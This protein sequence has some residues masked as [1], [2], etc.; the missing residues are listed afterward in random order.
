MQKNL[1][2]SKSQLLTGTALVLAASCF[3]G[4]PSYAQNTAATEGAIESVTVTG[5]RIQLQGYEAPTPVTVVDLGSLERD[6]RP[7][8]GDVLRNLPAFGA[9]SSPNNSARASLVSDGSAGLN[10][11]SLRNLGQLRTLVLFNGQRVVSSNLALGGTDL[12]TIPSSLVE[13][14]DVVTGGASASW[15]SDAV[16][17]VV[18]LIL[19][20]KL[21]GLRI[22]VEAGNN[23]KAEHAQYKGEVTYGQGFANDRGHV[24]VSGVYG[25]SPDT[26]FSNKIDGFQNQRLVN[27]PAY[28]TGAG[29]STS[30]PILIHAVN[31]GLAQ[32]TPGGIIS[33]GP[34][35]GIYFVGPNATPMRFD[36]GNVSGGYYT[37]GGTP[38]YGQ[39]QSDLGVL[40]FPQDNYTLFGYASYDITDDITASLQLNQGHYGSLVNTYSAIY[41]GSQ[42][43]SIEN[44]FLPASVAAQMLAAGVTTAPFGTSLT[45][46][47]IN[48]GGSIKG[49][50]NSLGVGVQ[51]VDRGLYRGVL[52]FDGKMNWFDNKWTWN[53]YFQ[54]G[55]VRAFYNGVNNQTN[56]RV[57]AAIDAVRVTTA[58]VGNSGLP[59][60]SIVCRSTLGA[61]T[62]GCIP[63][64]VFGTGKD[65]SQ[66]ASYINGVARAGG[67]QSHQILRQDVAAV[68]ATG[69]L[70]FGLEAGNVSTAFGIEYR[71][72]SGYAKVT[73]PSQA[74]TFYAG[75]PKNFSGVYSDKEAFVEFITPLLKDTGVKSLD[76]QLAGRYTDYSVS[77]GVETYKVG[78]TSEVNDDIRLRGTYSHDIRAPWLF[79]VF[80]TGAPITGSAID[81][82]TG[83]GV[84]IL[85]ITQGNRGLKPETANTLT[86]GVVLAPEE[87]IPGFNISA[88]W[89]RIKITGVIASASSTVTLAQCAA[90]VQVFCDNL[91]FAGPNGSLSAIISQPVNAA[92]QQTSGIDGQL[93]YRT[94]F[95]DGALNFHDVINYMIE[96]V[97]TAF[98]LTYDA[99]GAIGQ[100]TRTSVPKLK[101]TLT[102]TYA[103]DNWDLTAQGRVI[104]AAKL[105]NAWVSGRD[106]DN[107]TVPAIAYLDARASVKMYDNFQLYAAIDNVLGKAP[108]LVTRSSGNGSGY[109]APFRDTIYDAFGRV[110][111]VGLRA[112]F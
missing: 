30:V 22:N 65:T 101:S 36:Y 102:V 52:S 13:R 77:G 21:E 98:G 39:S 110:W 46:D 32:A 90:G 16:A 67:N 79:E 53:S 8:I 1:R 51:K 93:D 57:A 89:Y 88:D 66:A 23:F 105:N 25:K 104:G 76:M 78:F 86:A 50:A 109:E 84:S 10:L 33:G 71:R 27:N 19:N 83:Q 49:E 80:N 64:D 15:G 31:V 100:G 108:P 91:V 2:M 12:S 111:R 99:A 6:A 70:P 106:V 107:N 9:S 97:Q 59:I 47:L 56:T 85:G 92:L 40:S 18:N 35:K 28:G 11:V 43:I 44:P 63:L 82:K 48:G 60:G 34:L 4:V 87:W 55:E 38:N 5:S 54:H 103:Q 62:N 95:L 69:A 24:V 74:T 42:T 14:I 3:A 94:P 81:P 37:N 7:D 72:E 41:Y 26:F 112:K 20:T 61:P 73:A 75:N 45:Q 68:S 58:N 29:Q 96:D 17:G